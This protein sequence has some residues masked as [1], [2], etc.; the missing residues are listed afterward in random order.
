MMQAMRG[1]FSVLFFCRQFKKIRLIPK[2]RPFEAM[3]DNSPSTLCYSSKV[4]A[5]SRMRSNSLSSGALTPVPDLFGFCDPPEFRRLGNICAM[6]A[7]RAASSAFASIS[8]G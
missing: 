1:F 6:K 5:M 7:L 8:P 4:A 2:M 3:S